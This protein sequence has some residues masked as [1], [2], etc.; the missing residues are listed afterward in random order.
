MLAGASI[1]LGNNGYIW[2]SSVV[3]DDHQQPQHR[4]Q[5]PSSNEEGPV[6]EEDK[7]GWLVVSSGVILLCWCDQ[8]LCTRG[9]GVSSGSVLEDVVCPVALY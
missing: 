3:C 5:I 7:V 1:I 6:Q 4:F 2:L 9:C 8:W